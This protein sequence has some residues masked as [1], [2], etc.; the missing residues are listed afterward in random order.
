MAESLVR[1][2]LPLQAQHDHTA[3]MR[4]QSDDA[5]FQLEEKLRKVDM[6]HTQILQDAMNAYDR[7]DVKLVVSSLT[8]QLQGMAAHTCRTPWVPETNADASLCWFDLESAWAAPTLILR[9][10]IMHLHRWG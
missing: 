5:R 10:G 9:G 1:T 4:Q 3:A 2:A 8:W 7:W 6:A